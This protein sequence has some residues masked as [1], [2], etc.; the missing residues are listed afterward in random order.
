MPGQL[1]IGQLAGTTGFT[2]RTIRYYESLGLLQPPGRSESGYRLYSSGDVER[3]E[4]I[5][6]AKRLGLSLE[7]IRDILSLHARRQPCCVHVLALLDQ[8]LDFLDQLMREMREFRDELARLRQESAE[9]LEEF[10]AGPAICSIIEQAMHARS[11][12]ALAWL[13]SRAREGR[14]NAKDVSRGA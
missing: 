11:E 4:F 10:S 1:K 6:K 14:N 3:L 7:E 12:L 5:K 2:T 8:K 13:E 9:R